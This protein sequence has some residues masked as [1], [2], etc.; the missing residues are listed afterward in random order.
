MKKFYAEKKDDLFLFEDDEFHHL[1]VLRCRVG[2]EIICLT[3]DGFEYL[4]EIT[5]IEKKKAYAKIISK[6]L[7]DKN[8]NKQIAVFQGNVKGEKIDLIV[9]KLT[10]LGISEFY[11]FESSFTT[12]KINNNKIERL[13]KISME[14]C[15]QCGRSIPLKINEGLK[16]KEMLSLLEE[17]DIILFANEKEKLR[18]FDDLKNYNK[19][20]IIVGSE[21][22]FSDA[23]IEQ[24]N[25]L[26]VI[27]FGL[28]NRI[29][30]A[31]TAC[32]AMSS[33][34]CYLLDV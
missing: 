13:N 8:P 3:T 5:S 17:Y 11:T 25:Q 7:N 1:N 24:I 2:E 14:A 10:E 23:E 19:I 22:G 29:L 32:I 30:R 27:N 16:F 31:E 9:Q 20:A 33:I 18:N 26:N 4:C 34:I 15:K 6:K 28:G 21:G 12:A